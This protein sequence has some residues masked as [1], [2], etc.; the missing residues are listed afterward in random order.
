ML[1]NAFVNLLVFRNNIRVGT[2]VPNQK[3]EAAVRKL[4]MDN[5]QSLEVKDLE[6]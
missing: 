6:K 5:G 4:S 3:N 1:R 2:S